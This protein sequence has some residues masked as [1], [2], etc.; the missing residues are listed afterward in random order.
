MCASTARRWSS[1]WIAA[2]LSR[3]SFQP[4]WRARPLH[5]PRQ[6]AGEQEQR[7]PPKWLRLPQRNT[8]LF[9]ES[10]SGKVSESSPLFRLFL[11]FVLLDVGQDIPALRQGALIRVHHQ[12]SQ[13]V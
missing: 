4:T 6:T 12:V 10:L 13:V 1:A 8:L 9:P 5:T 7:S 3:P 2:I 11:S